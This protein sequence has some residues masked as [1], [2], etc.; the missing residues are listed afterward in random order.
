M[1]N[2]WACFKKIQRIHLRS[3]GSV[4]TDRYHSNCSILLLDDKEI[5]ATAA[6]TIITVARCYCSSASLL[7]F[8]LWSLLSWRRFHANWDLE[9]EILPCLSYCQ[10]ARGESCCSRRCCCYQDC[11]E[12][13]SQFS[14]YCVHC[15]IL[16]LMPAHHC[17]K[18]RRCSFLAA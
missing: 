1:T 15:W 11:Y 16:S 10:C 7:D 4:G 12:S 2:R 5:T 9:P 13:F 8:H 14:H 17:C 3:D 6:I 18:A